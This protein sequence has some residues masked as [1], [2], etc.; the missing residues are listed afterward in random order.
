[1][2]TAIKGRLTISPVTMAVTRH[3]DIKAR[4]KPARSGPTRGM[5]SEALA[6]VR[7][8]A[9]EAMMTRPPAPYGSAVS[10]RTHIG[11]GRHIG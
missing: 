7:P 3:L 9:P 4:P 10:V 6:F 11:T 2:R 5:A 8:P 1:M